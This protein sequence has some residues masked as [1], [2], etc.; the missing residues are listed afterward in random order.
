MKRNSSK[1]LLASKLV[2]LGGKIEKDED[3]L[4]SA[5]REF[6]EETGLELLNPIFKG[7]YTWIDNNF[8]GISHLIVSKEYKGRLLEESSEG[9]LAWYKINELDDLQDLAAY[10]KNFLPEILKTDN[11]VY[12]GIGI[13]DN[14]TLITYTDTKEYFRKK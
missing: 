6:L 10:Q 5:K 8:I 12:T 7:T 14:D 3:I 9:I 13:F 2:G 1:K 4:T 11:Y